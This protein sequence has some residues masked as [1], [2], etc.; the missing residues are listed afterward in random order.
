MQID[1]FAYLVK[2]TDRAIAALPHPGAE[3]T[4]YRHAL[5]SQQAY[6]SFVR[7]AHDAPLI[8]LVEPFE[9][10][11][12]MQARLTREGTPSVLY[13][14]GYTVDDFDAEFGRMRRGGW[15]PLTRP[16][17]GLT[18]GCRASHL[19]NPDFGVVEI[20]EVAQ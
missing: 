10:N 9:G 7:T 1:H 3:V 8:E 15:M 11:A 4:L 13:H 14:V 16:F 18:P 20:M 17:E 5:D 2:D 12:V 6:I 19:Y